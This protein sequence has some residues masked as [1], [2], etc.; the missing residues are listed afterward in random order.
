MI[1]IECHF[2]NIH[3]TINILYI[4]DFICKYHKSNKK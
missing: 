1:V 2:I 3:E 4:L